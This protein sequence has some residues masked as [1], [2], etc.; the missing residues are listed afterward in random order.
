MGALCIFLSTACYCDYRYRKIPNVLL[1][2]MLITGLVRGFLNQGGKGIFSFLLV[3]IVLVV[4][5]YPL[6]RVG[7][8]GAGDV[9]LFGVC[10]GYLPYD[11]ILSFLFFSLLIAAMISLLKLITNHNRKEC[12][13]M[14]IPLAGPVLVGILLYIGGV[15]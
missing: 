1:I 2:L 13:K 6:F 7:A 12:L 9:K 3:C 5:L 11:K 10:S 15:Y 4:L 14:G 8:L